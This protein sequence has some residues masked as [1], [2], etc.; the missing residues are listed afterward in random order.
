MRLDAHPAFFIAQAAGG[1]R[2]SARLVHLIAHAPVA[3]DNQ[4]DP[5]NGLR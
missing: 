3:V 2:L 5:Q 4:R 1:V